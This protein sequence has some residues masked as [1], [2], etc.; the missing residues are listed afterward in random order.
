MFYID[1][2]C[3]CCKN[4]GGGVSTYAARERTQTQKQ[5]VHIY[6]HTHTHASSRKT[7]KREKAKIYPTITT[8]TTTTKKKV[9]GAFL[10]SPFGCCKNMYIYILLTRIM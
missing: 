2:I 8:T 4:K 9:A 3:G 6:A 5:K 10:D 7:Q 1:S